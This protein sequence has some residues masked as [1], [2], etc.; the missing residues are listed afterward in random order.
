MMTTS[1]SER[2]NI[3]TWNIP[4]VFFVVSWSIV[5]NDD[6]AF[7]GDNAA[8]IVFECKIDMLGCLNFL[9]TS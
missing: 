2:H 6:C 4:F 7:F 8:Q 5:L 1:T 9:F 3:G